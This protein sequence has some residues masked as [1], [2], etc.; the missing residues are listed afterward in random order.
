[1][2]DEQAFLAQL[3]S[4]N[5]DELSQILRRPSVDE[6]RVL[7]TYFGANRLRRLRSLALGMRRR[8]LPKGNVVVLHGIMGGTDRFSEE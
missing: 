1:M 2:I 5:T 3:E 4:A 6:E 8:A 7:E